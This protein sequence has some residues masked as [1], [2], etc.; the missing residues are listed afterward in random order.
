[1]LALDP[2]Q[3]FQRP[4]SPDHLPPLPLLHSCYLMND[5][6]PIIINDDVELV[7][8]LVT[9]IPVKTDGYVHRIFLRLEQ[10]GWLLQMEN[11][12][13]MHTWKV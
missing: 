9:I 1:M 7:A 13:F 8:I 12:A 11:V 2:R 4:L 10:L 5:S 6:K 3:H